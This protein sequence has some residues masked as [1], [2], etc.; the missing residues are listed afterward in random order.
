MTDHYEHYEGY[1]SKYFIITCVQ[2][3]LYLSSSISCQDSR[4]TSNI[5]KVIFKRVNEKVAFTTMLPW[6]ETF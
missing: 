1:I 5:K 2:K 6:F 3:Q 4:Q